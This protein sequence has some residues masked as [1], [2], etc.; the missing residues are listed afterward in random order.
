MNSDSFFEESATPIRL[1]Q[2]NSI[3]PL[4]LRNLNEFVGV[5]PPSPLYA[6]PQTT[7][8]ESPLSGKKSLYPVVTPW[9]FGRPIFPEF[10]SENQEN[11]NSRN[12]PIPFCSPFD[13]TRQDVQGRSVSLNH[14]FELQT[15][16]SKELAVDLNLD[17]SEKTRNTIKKVFLDSSSPASSRSSN[18]VCEKNRSFWR[19]VMGEKAPVI[20]TEKSILSTSQDMD[21]DAT[22]T[23]PATDEADGVLDIAKQQKAE[24]SDPDFEISNTKRNKPVKRNRSSS[25]VKTRDRRHTKRNPK[26]QRW[27]E[28]KKKKKKLALEESKLTNRK[29]VLPR[30]KNGCWTCR[31]RR[32]RCPEDKPE[33]SECVRLG[34][35]CDG[36]L[37]EK[38]WFAL[39][40]EAGRYRME[41]IKQVTISKKGRGGNKKDQVMTAYVRETETSS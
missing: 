36:Y 35:E 32:K 15:P 33:C 2:I 3:F 31:L 27:S 37:A 41:Q 5:S 12:L 11:L 25:S 39:S 38:P 9:S 21:D 18:N 34:L 40:A 23:A 28:E 30:S 20:L 16:R 22:I 17:F 10:G 4:R 1:P 26:Q 13:R 7:P 29:T 6:P 19:T 24:S 14:C 8:V